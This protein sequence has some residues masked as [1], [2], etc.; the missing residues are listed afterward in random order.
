MDVTIGCHGLS[1]IR[2]CQVES[3]VISSTTAHFDL[4]YAIRYIL[5]HTGIRFNWKHI[6]GHQDNDENAILDKWA[7]FNIQ[8][9]QEAK[10]YWQQT[11]YSPR[12]F[13]SDRIFGEPGI[14]GFETKKL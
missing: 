9:D 10:D 11:I 8:M 2:C 13:P 4:I 5:R 6:K 1:A 3:D 14:Y 12:E 7:M